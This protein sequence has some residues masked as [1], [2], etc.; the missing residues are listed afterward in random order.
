MSKYT[1]YI[2]ISLYEKL[3]EFNIYQKNLDFY[4]KYHKNIDRKSVV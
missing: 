3:D 4:E 1:K 2:P